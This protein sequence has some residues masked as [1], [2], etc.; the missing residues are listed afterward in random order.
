M[1]EIIIIEK[2]TALKQS[3]FFIIFAIFILSFQKTFA[4]K[5][6]LI[7]QLPS[8]EIIEKRPVSNSAIE[9]APH[10]II[11]KKEIKSLAPVQVSEILTLSPGVSICDYGGLSGIKTISIRGS[12]SSRTLVML[13]GMPISSTQNS[14]FDL[15]NI[16]VPLL[17]DIEILRGGASAIFG[18]NAV[19]GAINLRTDFMPNHIAKCTFAAGSFGEKSVNVES[20]FISDKGYISTNAGYLYSDGDFPFDYNQFGKKITTYRNNAD[21][22]NFSFSVSGKTNLNDWNLWTRAIY[23]KI[24]KGV[25]GAVLQG[26]LKDSQ[27]RMYDDKFM[28][29]LNSQRLFDIN[30]A[31]KLSAIAKI[32]N[33][34]Y[35]EPVKTAQQ[36]SYFNLKDFGIN[37]KFMSNFWDIKHEV[38]SSAFLSTLNG[39]MLDPTTDSN[40]ARQSFALA[41]RLEDQ[42]P[43]W[44][45]HLLE[46]SAGM[47]LDYISDVETAFSYL[48]GTSYK[49][50]FLPM[51]LKA[52]FSHNFRP[53]NFNEMY[54][55]NYG[56]KNLRAEKSH[57][58]NFGVN[59]DVFKYFSLEL[60]TFFINT[61]DMIV[62]VPKTPVTWSAKNLDKV[63]S[64][65]LE[66]GFFLK[67]P[68][69]FLN[70]LSISYTFQKTKDK[71]PNAITYDKQ[72]VYVPQELLTFML[73]CDCYGVNIGS[74]GDYSSFRYTQAD[75]DARA[76]LPNYFVLDT[77]AYKN[78]NLFDMDFLLRFT[79]KNIFDKRYALVQNYFMPGRSFRFSLE[80]RL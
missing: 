7:K 52:S 28:F 25:P 53:P 55:R 71:T 23:N 63:Y 34:C 8:V 5:D 43:M 77:Y 69:S 65:G 48:L 68:L 75:N 54:Y 41:Y 27:D 46:I 11:G 60:E 21:Y 57:N 40:V 1:K 13:D 74:K 70:N 73:E 56:T 67:Q 17:G 47:R 3:I 24:E 76:I 66:F 42:I 49:L 32:D 20:N 6:T 33:S 19:G 44:K 38:I 79:C 72:I 16:A 37:A 39:N 59:I 12:G 29:I 22:K 9:F 61:R 18:G 64:N 2:K 36:K 30:S 78:F 10:K 26:K 14:S 35:E 80:I 45:K 58:L 4:K 51:K 31:L 62:S 15:S 50:K